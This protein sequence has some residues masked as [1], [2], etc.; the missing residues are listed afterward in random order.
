MGAWRITGPAL[1][2]LETWRTWRNNGG[3]RPSI[4]RSKDSQGPLNQDHRRYLLLVHMLVRPEPL[5][6]L[7]SLSP[8]APTNILIRLETVKNR[9]SMLLLKIAT[10]LPFVTI[11]STI[12][13][14]VCRRLGPRHCGDGLRP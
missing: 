2:D 13:A 9:T 14:L 11:F 1:E 4:S 8:I 6:E 5:H 7:L 10:C 3:E 12:T